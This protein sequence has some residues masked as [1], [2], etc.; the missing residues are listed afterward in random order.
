MTET[1]EYFLM[2][3]IKCD[4]IL[5]RLNEIQDYQLL[6]SELEDNTLDDDSQLGDFLENDGTI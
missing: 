2:I 6:E 1:A 5:N 3:I 4:D